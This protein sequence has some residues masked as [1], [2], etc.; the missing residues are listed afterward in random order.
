MRTILII[1]TLFVSALSF[2]QSRN[3]KPNLEQDLKIFLQEEFNQNTIDPGVRE[4]LNKFRLRQRTAMGLTLGAFGLA[5]LAAIVHNQN[6]KTNPFVP[7]TDGVKGMIVA[8][9]VLG[10]AAI[11][12]EWTSYNYLKF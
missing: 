11:V 4:S 2:G 1:V 12:T 3:L 5:G 7:M 8:S 10:F 6:V 9:G